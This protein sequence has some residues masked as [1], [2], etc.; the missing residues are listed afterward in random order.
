MAFVDNFQNFA[1]WHT[2][3]YAPG[4]EIDKDIL[5][6]GNKE[7]C[8]TNC[9]LVPKDVNKFFQTG[10][11]SKNKEELLLGVMLPKLTDRKN[12]RKKPY[13]GTWDNSPLFETQEECNLAWVE[14]K[15]KRL[16]SLC[17]RYTGD[18]KDERFLQAMLDRAATLE[19]HLQNK[20]T[21]SGW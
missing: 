20:L 10:R 19:Y 21:F 3:W 2:E 14:Q 5:S 7:Y 8:P 17:E 12:H 9:M 18:V 13:V 11:M 4:L 16:Y 6:I 15:L 1:Q